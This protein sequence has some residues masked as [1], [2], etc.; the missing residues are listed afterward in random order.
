MH[1]LC[2][3]LKILVAC[4]QCRYIIYKKKLMDKIDIQSPKVC[5]SPCS[6]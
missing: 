1:V 3:Y 5:S 2:A 6:S 4:L